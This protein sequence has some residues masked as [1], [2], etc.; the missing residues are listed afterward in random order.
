MKK[1]ITILAFLLLWSSAVTRA[2]DT[3]ARQTWVGKLS[4]SGMELTLV[5]NVFRLSPDTI[6]AT[7]DSPDQGAKGIPVSRIA[8]TSDSL[9]FK[10]N[11]LM[12]SYAGRFSKDDDTLSG[13]FIQSG[14]RIPLTMT[15]QE[16]EYKLNRPQ[17]PRPPFS[18]LSEE[19][20]IKNPKDSLELSGTLTRP[21]GPGPFPAVV[22][23][24]GSGPQN[25]D[26]EIFGH[27]PF[28]VLADR[29]TKA[30]FA[31][32][33]YDDRGIGKSTGKFGSATTFDFV[34][35]ADAAFDFLN[36]RK[37]IDVTRSGILGHSE[38]GLIAEI[39][40]GTRHDIDFIVLLAG[41]ALTGE[42]ILQLQSA[43][44]ARASGATEQ[45]ISANEEINS[46]IYSILKKTPDN[47]KAAVKI[48]KA[49]EDFTK[50]NAADNPK[51]FPEDQIEAQIRTVTSPWFRTFLTLDPMGY[52][53]K[54]RCPV[55][56][57]F[58]EM[59]LQVPPAENMKA[60]ETG[61]L[62]S[63][64]E[65][66]TIEYIPGVNH[67]FQTATTG[68]PSEYGQIEETFSPVALDMITEWLKRN[69]K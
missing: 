40:A 8:V 39:I 51:A 67:L 16:H 53:E 46:K 31:V 20:V 24:T 21:D 1:T 10:V 60:L 6:T 36:N 29:L 17:E 11:N 33:R 4:F 26:E 64:N 45:M 48:R 15:V 43:L 30:G 61:L 50:K 9:K 23:V 35:D 2:G 38:G 3:I 56:A 13:I 5:L 66:Y 49:L 28:L 68:S 52:I 25:R 22:L 32:L 14:Y 7:L 42:K 41:T 37:D 19:V 58:G 44:I 62:F 47:E 18:Y 55:L 69:V 59:D 63:G 27:K 57:L 12:A 65:M 54:I 34:S